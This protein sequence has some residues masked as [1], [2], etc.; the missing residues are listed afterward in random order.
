MQWL[1]SCVPQLVHE[2][3]MA[4]AMERATPPLYNL[5]KKEKNAYDKKFVIKCLQTQVIRMNSIVLIVM[6][7]RL[8]KLDISHNEWWERRFNLQPPAWGNPELY[9]DLNQGQY[10]NDRVNTTANARDWWKPSPTRIPERESPLHP[11]GNRTLTFS[12]DNHET[13]P[14]EWSKVKENPNHN[15]S[16]LCLP[17][18]KTKG[19]VFGCISCVWLRGRWSPP[20][21]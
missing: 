5:K 16:A 13:K 1:L 9:V 14:W 19:I 4:F 12:F 18:K 17:P 8:I 6:C 2:C 3:A 7:N 10:L 21:F 20:E 15:H 11:T